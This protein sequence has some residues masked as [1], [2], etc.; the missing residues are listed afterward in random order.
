MDPSKYAFSS[1]AVISPL[2][3]TLL[4]MNLR[5]AS[6]RRLH[7]CDRNIT[8]IT[9]INFILQAWRIQNKDASEETKRD[10]RQKTLEFQKELIRI[11]VEIQYRA[12]KN[13]W[14]VRNTF[15]SKDSLTLASWQHHL[16]SSSLRY[17]YHFPWDLTW[18]SSNLTYSVNVC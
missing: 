9:W 4:R 11:G 2:Y 13:Q 3:P 8:L 15:I 10:L 14:K 12:L 7:I 6:S 17:S 16:S 5:I 18:V 1:D